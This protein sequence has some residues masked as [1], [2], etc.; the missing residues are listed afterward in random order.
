VRGAVTVRLLGVVLR[1]REILWQKICWVVS[2]FCWVV[3]VFRWVVSMQTFKRM[4]ITL[5]LLQGNN[6]PDHTSKHGNK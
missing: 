3:S 6:I 5:I 2:M 4:T 1:V